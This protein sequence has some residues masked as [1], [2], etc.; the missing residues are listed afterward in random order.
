[1]S[2]YLRDE[3]LTN[4]DVSENS[5]GTLNALL[6]DIVNRANDGILEADPR[7]LRIKYV[8]RFD[9]KG[10]TLTDFGRL[11]NYYRTARRVERLV[12]QVDSPLSANRG[13]YKAVDLALWGDDPNHCILT[14]Q[15]DDSEWTDSI[16]LRVKEELGGH[17]NRLRAFVRTAW[18]NFLLQ[19]SGTLVVFM[20]SFLAALKTSVYFAPNYVLGLLLLLYLIIF[21]TIWTYLY[22]RLLV[23]YA[24]LCP[25]IKFKELTEVDWVIRLIAGAV[26]V[27][28]LGF[29][30][31]EAISYAADAI[32]PL[33]K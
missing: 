31:N 7:F 9:K 32:R 30:A 20:L 19:L 12:I 1:M 13:A 3:F 2:N 11:L 26:I 10:F 21:S 28:I 4:I 24:Q 16:F 22:P 18:V 29:A 5:L 23:L 17:K 14:V 33:L 15:D 6:L 27:G 8:I 25:N